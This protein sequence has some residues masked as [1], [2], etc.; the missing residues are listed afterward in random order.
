[1]NVGFLLLQHEKT[2]HNYV[3]SKLP[4][5]TL[6][7]SSTEAVPSLYFGIDKTETFDIV[8]SSHALVCLCVHGSFNIILWNPATKVT[9][10]V[11]QSQMSYP[12]GKVYFQDIGSVSTSNLLTTRWS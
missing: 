10:V 4:Y 5:E 11:P 6:E 12:Q 3:L 1:M 7:I 9:K 8:G 2:S